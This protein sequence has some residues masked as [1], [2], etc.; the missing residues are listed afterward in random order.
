MP[1]RPPAVA[2]LTSR[3]TGR[4]PRGKKAGA[5]LGLALLAGCAGEGRQGYPPPP[6]HPILV[7]PQPASLTVAGVGPNGRLSDDDRS[8]VSAFLDA[9]HER[10]RGPLSLTVSGLDPARARR[11]VEALTN[12]AKRRGVP[13]GAIGPVTTA[14][15]VPGTVPP[16]GVSLGFTD[17]VAIPPDC[18]REIA[19]TADF[20]NA[21]SPNH[22]CASQRSLAAMIASPA[23]LLAPR[24][25]VPADGPRLARVIDQYR[26]GRDTASQSASTGSAVIARIA[27]GK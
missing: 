21:P 16:S 11:T 7:M 15:I 19:A 22:G 1:A 17:F 14:A 23:D 27:G 10:A 20:D 24:P 2:R 26:Q 4:F 12:A 13:A 18:R 6:S 5:L 9:Y 25:G 3:V 8:R